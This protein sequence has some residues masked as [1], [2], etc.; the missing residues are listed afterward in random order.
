[1]QQSKVYSC[2]VTFLLV[3]LVSIFAVSK[4]Q[5]QNGFANKI[6][7]ISFLG[8]QDS[9][10]N[11]DMIKGVNQIHAQWIAAIPEGT[12]DRSTLQILPDS[13][14][15]N[16]SETK[17]GIINLI[18]LS[19]ESGMRIMLKPQVVLGENIMPND[20]L[21]ELASYV[22]LQY[23]EITDKTYGAKWRGDFIAASE[24]DWRHWE[25]SYEQ[26]I[27]EYARLAKDYN[28][29]IFCIGTE[30]REFVIHRPNFWNTLIQKV[31]SIYK[32]PLTY[33]A[34]WDEFDIVPFWSKLDFIGTNTYFPIAEDRTPNVKKVFSSWRKIRTRIRK[35]SQRENKKVLITE[36]GYRNVDYAGLHPW[37][38][39]NG[40]RQ[41]TNDSA[42][43]N[44]YEAF[45]KALWNESWIMGGFGWNWIY[46]AQPVGNTDFSIQGKPALQVV[47]KYYNNTSN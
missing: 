24:N 14:N 40:H 33:S 30:L 7:G 41:P 39:V 13:S 23:E 36:Y 28:V 43:F 4:N 42:Q 12:I 21:N 19:Q 11:L 38:H 20:L 32:G 46:E 29:D 27:L 34:N 2:S 45:F 8:P 18:E 26:Y 5:G 47:T 1:M 31:R 3:L 22:N 15:S 9:I 44:L 10:L 6:K 35:V 25:Y 16:W 17:A 37:L